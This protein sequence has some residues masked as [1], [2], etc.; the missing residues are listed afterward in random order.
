MPNLPLKQDEPADHE[1]DP[2]VSLFRF[3]FAAAFLFCH[4][5]FAPALRTSSA[6][7]SDMVASPFG[8]RFLPPNRPRCTAA[9]F[10]R[11]A[12]PRL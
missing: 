10:F 9:G 1:L 8:T 4:I 11:F 7:S 3:F 2:W 6:F 12:M 5:A